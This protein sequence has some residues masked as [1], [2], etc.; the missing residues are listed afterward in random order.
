MEKQVRAPDV[1]H[2]GLRWFNVPAPLSLR[3]LAGRLVI[4]DFWTFCCI[5]CMHILPIL[6]RVEE[7]FPREVAVIGV[8]SPKFAAEKDPDNVARAIA[9]YGIVHPVVHDPECRIWRSYAVRA[10]P[11]LVFVSPDGYVLGA[12]SGEPD[13]DALLRGLS[14]VVDQMRSAGHAAPGALPLAPVPPAGGR[15][16]FPG[17]LRPLRGGEKAWAL[18]DSGHHQIAVLDDAGRDR[19]RAGSGEPGW[20]DG[21]MGEARFQS[22]QGLAADDAA[23]YVADTW[24]HRIRRIDRESGRVTTLA[25]TGARGLALGGPAPGLQTALASPWDLEV[26]G[27]RLFFANAGTHQLGV[28]DLARGTAERLAGS[29]AEALVDGP[30]AEAAL[31]QPSGLALDPH[32]ERLYFVDSETSSVRYV[33]LNGR[34]EVHTLAG[35]GLFD[36]GHEN[37]PL[38]RALFQHPLGI[39]WLEGGGGRLLVADSYNGALRV[40][41]LRRQWASDLDD[42]FDCADPVCLPAGEP[43]GAAVDTP[44]RVF[45]VDTNN[46]RIL[47]YLVRE[48]TYRTWSQ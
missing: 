3:D 7:A 48:R 42:G 40:V 32:G 6:R 37:G 22:P 15:F 2:P 36:F 12:H 27:T 18:C 39:A 10:W 35:K 38:D 9:R 30:A 28:V 14:Q 26:R 46:H 1:A 19:G 20:R 4:L 23:I 24:N 47:E 43:A 17:K 34:P 25:G 44:E 11:T 5:N 21:E 31:A 41:D 45:M 33:S 16:A 8:H 29:G 13:P